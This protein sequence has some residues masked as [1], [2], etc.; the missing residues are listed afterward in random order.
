MYHYYF[1]ELLENEKTVDDLGNVLFYQ[2][3]ICPQ[4][5]LKKVAVFQRQK[6]QPDIKFLKGRTEYVEIVDSNA[7]LVFFDQEENRYVGSAAY[8]LNQI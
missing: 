4:D 6:R 3:L 5:F 2:E 7:L 1:E 8:Q